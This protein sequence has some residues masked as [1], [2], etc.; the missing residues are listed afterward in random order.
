MALAAN[1]RY[2]NYDR[3]REIEASNNR[4]SGSWYVPVRYNV[5]R[6][7]RVTG[8]KTIIVGAGP[9]G[10][11]CAAALS[12]RGRSSLVLERAEN[13]AAAWHRHYDRLHL[14]THKMHSGLPGKPMPRSFPKYPSRLQVIEYLEDYARSHGIEIRFRQ[15]VTSIQKLDSWSIATVG[16]TFQAE[17]VIVATGL[18]HTPVRPQWKGQESFAGTLVHSSEF[19]NAAEL[20]VKRVLVVGFG[21]SAG[22]IALECAEAG[23]EVGLS[24]RS[25]INVIPRE[26]LGVPTLSI[27]IAQQIFPYRL[28]DAMNAPFLRLRFGN[29]GK[30]GLKWAPYG[31][32]T[33]IMER[34]R[35]PL[36]DIGT[37]ERI[38]SGDIR[39]LGGISH[40]EDQYVCFGDGRR[41]AFDAIVLATGYRSAL[42]AL[43]PDR[44]KIFGS[45]DGPPRGQLH[46]AGDGLYFCGFNV[47]PTGHLRQIGIEA[48]QIA[49]LVAQ[50]T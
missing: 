13:I 47:V 8:S 1:P 30:F 3:T 19:K 36:I 50:G 18:A 11:A 49:E 38:R 16:E 43:F 10:L 14:H 40:L 32:L 33:S 27:A 12:Q 22:E 15:G 48:Q 28:V 17:S 26:M 7:S 5:D 23:I 9:A 29:I 44:Q 20:N 24:V 37:M 25:P 45:S 42:A 21:N 46:P 6:E 2:Q 31:P 4:H 34:G 35:T 39:V 41:K